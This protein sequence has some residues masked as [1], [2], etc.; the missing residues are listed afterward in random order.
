[1]VVVLSV[2]FSPWTSGIAFLWH[3]LIGAVVVVVV[4]MA[5]SY[6]QTPDAASNKYESL[7]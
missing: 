6:T 3:N 5:L 4:G 7:A 2:A 1:M